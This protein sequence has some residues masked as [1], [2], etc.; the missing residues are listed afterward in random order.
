MVVLAD[1]ARQ[2]HIDVL[3]GYFKPIKPAI[4]LDIIRQYMQ[5]SDERHIILVATDEDDNAVGMILGD[6]SDKPWLVC[7]RVAH[8]ANLIVSPNVRRCG[9][10]K[11]LMDAF[12]A[13]CKKHGVQ[14]LTLGVYNKNQGSY[15]FYVEY[16]FEPLEQK[17]CIKL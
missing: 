15:N 12:V 5:N 11:R 3:G 10:G 1:H 13:E 4:E 2:H 17:M 6:V 8:V 9:V 7:P 16:G 14:E